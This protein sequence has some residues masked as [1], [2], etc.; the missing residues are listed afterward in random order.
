MTI[1]IQPEE[2][3]PCRDHPKYEVSDA[4]RIRRVG[5]A[6]PLKP[7]THRSGHLYVRLNGRSRQVHHLVM[8]AF[9]SPRPEG[10]DCRHLDGDPTNNRPGN[11]E[12]GT[13]QQNIFDHIRIHGMAVNPRSTKSAVAA[14]IKEEH[15]GKFGTGKRLAEKYGVSVYTVSEI[16]NGKTFKYL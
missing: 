9:G 15:D 10:M 3:K 13:R 14:L 7:W 11:L 4:G 1:I 8:D 6:H 5:S 2:W 16:K 12:W